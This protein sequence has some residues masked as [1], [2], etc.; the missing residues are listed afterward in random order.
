MNTINAIRKHK[1]AI[2]KEM[3]NLLSQIPISTIERE[4]ER[5]YFFF[6]SEVNRPTYSIMHF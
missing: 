6:L 2:R 3:R 5:L 1:S 4:S